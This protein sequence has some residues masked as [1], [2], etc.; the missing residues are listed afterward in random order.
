MW[1]IENNVDTIWIEY[2]GSGDSGDIRC[3]T[4][5]VPSDIQDIACDLFTQIVHP[6]FNNSGSYGDAGFFI[7]DGV[8]TFQCDHH[9][10]IETTDDKT[11][12]QDLLDTSKL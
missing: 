8:L 4:K 6:S 10:I 11:Y 1:M 9:D 3:N 2:S 12:D 7:R 5:G